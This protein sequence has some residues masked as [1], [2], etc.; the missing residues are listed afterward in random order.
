MLIDQL[1]YM[2]KSL[3]DKNEAF[4]KLMAGRTPEQAAVALMSS[5]ILGSKEKFE[6]LANAKQDEI[7]KTADPVL[8]FAC[9]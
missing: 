5:S 8:D 1:T 7:T 6:L 3:S 2:K 9:L 4:N